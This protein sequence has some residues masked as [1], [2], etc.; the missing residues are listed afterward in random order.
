MSSYSLRNSAITIGHFLRFIGFGTFSLRDG[1]VH[2]TV[3]DFTCLS[4]NVS[5]GFI[6]LYLSVTYGIG[7]LGN[8]SILLAMGV[9]LTM[10]CGSL[11]VIIST[12]MVFIQR[13][14]IWDVIT[15]LDIVMDK[16]RKIHVYP[17]FKRYIVGFL[18]FLLFTAFLILLGLF[19][20]A[21]FLGYSNRLNVLFIYGYLSASFAAGMGWV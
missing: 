16:F 8:S 13:Y 14:R 9:L 5:I 3:F 10:V 17:N 12:L 19:I 20:M 11:V 2:V 15:I 6:M 18:L 1:K 4:F 21:M 7:R